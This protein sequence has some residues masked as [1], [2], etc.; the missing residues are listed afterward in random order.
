MINQ[1][2]PLSHR[3]E[4][5][6][7]LHRFG[8]ATLRHGKSRGGL[9]HRGQGGWRRGNGWKMKVLEEMMVRKGNY[10][11]IYLP[12]YLSIYRSF[13]LSIYIYISRTR[14]Y[15]S[16]WSMTLAW[17]WYAPFR[18]RLQDCTLQIPK[19]PPVPVQFLYCFSI[20]DVSQRLQ[21]PYLGKGKICEI[22]K[23]KSNNI[24]FMNKMTHLHQFQ[25]LSAGGCNPCINRTTAN[26]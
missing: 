3:A 1:C 13:F 23:T 20:R 19:F 5:A 9:Y 12:I 11:F 25:R 4:G 16:L 24:V 2:P 18:D 6:L 15:R 14:L 7:G 10:L 22:S 26:P 21:I 17:S 8:P